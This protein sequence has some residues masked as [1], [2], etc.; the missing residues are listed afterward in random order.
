MLLLLQGQRELELRE[1]PLQLRVW[2]PA[3]EPQE[4][5]AASQLRASLRV[6]LEPRVA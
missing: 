5:R 2:R 3:L 6:Q 4:L 1:L